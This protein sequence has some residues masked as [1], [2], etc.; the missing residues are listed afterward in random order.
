MFFFDRIRNPRK[1]KITVPYSTVGSFTR[2]CAKTT[3]TS[4]EQSKSMILRMS[5]MANEGAFQ[6]LINTLKEPC[7]YLKSHLA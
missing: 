3:V 1:N 2:F 4:N 5:M 7:Y 6:I